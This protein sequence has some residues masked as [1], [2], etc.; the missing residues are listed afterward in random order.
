MNYDLQFHCRIESGGS[1][2]CIPWGLQSGHQ[3]VVRLT[4]KEFCDASGTWLSECHYTALH[5]LVAVY[6]TTPSGD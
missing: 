2:N 1:N 6:D 3:N 5:C 4:T